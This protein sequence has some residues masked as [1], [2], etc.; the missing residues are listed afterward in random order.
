MDDSRVLLVIGLMAVGTYLTR[1]AGL[2]LATRLKLTGRGETF[3]QALPGS[4]LAAIV[5]PAVFAQGAA[6]VVAAAATAVVAIR[7]GRLPLAMAT[8]VAVVFAMRK[9]I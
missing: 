3:L 6:E 7:T 4:I 5:A 1:A 9:I 8:G 2:F